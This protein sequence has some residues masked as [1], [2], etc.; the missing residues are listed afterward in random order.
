M[1]IR[2]EG[3]KSEGTDD[4]KQREIMSQFTSFTASFTAAKKYKKMSGDCNRFLY[5]LPPPCHTQ[6]YFCFQPP[7]PP[8]STTSQTHNAGVITDVCSRFS[9][10]FVLFIFWVF[11]LFLLA[12][13][14]SVHWE[15]WHLSIYFYQFQHLLFSCWLMSSPES[16]SL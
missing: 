2:V 5:D 14:S 12:H 1:P 9:T 10:F 4:V 3:S 15:P 11:Y 6:R 7:L 8:P 16:F 13:G